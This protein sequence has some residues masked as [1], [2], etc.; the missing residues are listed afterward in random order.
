[1]N[2][3]RTLDAPGRSAGANEVS[4]DG[5]SDDGL[6]VANGPYVYVVQAGGRQ[7]SGRILVLN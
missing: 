2:P 1:M 5:L 7:L 6:R 3:I 4:W